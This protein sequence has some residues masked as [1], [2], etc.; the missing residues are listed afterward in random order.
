MFGIDLPSEV[1]IGESVSK[2]V[3]FGRFEGE[4]VIVKFYTADDLKS[5]AAKIKH[6]KQ[7][8]LMDNFDEIETTTEDR[9]IYN[10]YVHYLIQKSLR[11]GMYAEYYCH[12][13]KKWIKKC[14]VKNEDRGEDNVYGCFVKLKNK[15]MGEEVTSYKENSEI[16]FVRLKHIVGVKFDSETETFIP[17]NQAICLIFPKLSE[18]VMNY[19][20]GELKWSVNS[21]YFYIFSDERKIS[22]FFRNVVLALFFLFEKLNIVHKDIKIENICT[23]KY[24]DTHL[25]VIIDFGESQILMGD[26]RLMDSY[27]T[28][29]MLPPEAFFSSFHDYIGSFRGYCSEKREIWTLGCLLHIMVFGYPPLFDILSEKSPI[30]FQLSLCDKN[31]KIEIPKYSQIIQKETSN[32]LNHLLSGLLCKNPNSRFSFEDVLKDPWVVGEIS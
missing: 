24:G 1:I 8:N 13:E 16:P 2:R 4:S 11:M 15:L 9:V 19:N 29:S 20:S 22:Q 32:E 17:Q 14:V 6:V 26:K 28:H 25:P 5:S 23:V 3:F 27:G 31:Q 21:E 10:I 30:E 18:P 7:D 12:D